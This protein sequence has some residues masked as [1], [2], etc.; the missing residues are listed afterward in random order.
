MLSKATYLKCRITYVLHL[1]KT[2]EGLVL[3]HGKLESLFSRFGSKMLPI[4]FSK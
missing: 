4:K 2:L 3:V 1:H